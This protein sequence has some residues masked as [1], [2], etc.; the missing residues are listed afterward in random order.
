MT[1]DIL[2]ICILTL[3]DRKEYYNRLRQCLDNQVANHPV[4]ILTVRDN[5]ERSIGAK[6]NQAVEAV[7]T[8][9]LCFIDDDD[10]VSTEYVRTVIA[11]LRKDPDAVG[12]RGIVTQDNGRPQ[13][14]INSLGYK[15]E[16]KA[17]LVQ[18][19]ITY[20]RPVNHL[21]PIRTEIAL[22]YPYVETN[23]AEDMDYA[24]RLM[25]G[26]DVKVC[27]LIDKVMYFYQYRS[28]K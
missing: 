4:R 9:Y 1:D 26:G 11:E 19:N 27:P 13:Y 15:W 20:L 8:P 5:Y 7:Q 28:K 12:L 3:D 14:F 16:P 10:L 17:R 23:H 18:G 24:N 21:N 2:T 6:R 22:K 25:A